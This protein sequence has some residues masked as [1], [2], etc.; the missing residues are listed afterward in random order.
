[1]HEAERAG[2]GERRRWRSG[3]R[4]RPARAGPRPG[5]GPTTSRTSG[6]DQ[7]R[8]AGVGLLD[9]VVLGRDAAEQARRGRSRAAVRG[10]PRPRRR[11]RPSR[12]CRARTTTTTASRPPVGRA[13][14]GSP[15]GPRRGLASL[16][17]PRRLACRSTTAVSGEPRP[18]REV[19]V[20]APRCRGS[21]WSAGSRPGRSRSCRGGRG[22]RGRGRARPAETTTTIGRERRRDE[23]GD[24]LPSGGSARRGARPRAPARRR[25]RRARESRAGRRVKARGEHHRDPDRQDRPEP[26][27]RL[28][29]GDAAGRA[30]PRSPCPPR[31][32]SPATLSR[33]ASG[34]ASAARAAALQL[35]AVAVDEQQRVVGA[36]AEDEHQEQEA[37]PR[38]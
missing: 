14:P 35:L 6:H 32:R 36:G 5:S 11:P 33:S 10:S 15:A 1:M 29:V 4:A 3:R 34:S 37:C 28:Q 22:C 12:G 23:A 30:S 19:F 24:P 8:V 38:C 7:P 25:A 26:V 13:A 18:G 31:R 17:R 21:S 9:V 20:R 2:E 27:G 16:R